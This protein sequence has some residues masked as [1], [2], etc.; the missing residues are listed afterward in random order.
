MFK[1]FYNTLRNFKLSSLLNIAGLTIAFV[2][3]II[4]M[5]QVNFDN[6][7]DTF[8]TKADRIYR[9]E[10]SDDSMLYSHNISR[11]IGE[12]L[13]NSSTDI[14]AYSTNFIDYISYKVVG[15][16]E[17][18]A[19]SMG[20]L[21]SF[22]PDMIDIFDFK[23]L[24]GDKECIADPNTIIISE[25]IAKKISPTQ[26]A[27]GKEILVSSRVLKIG[28]VY[29][30]F[31][32]NTFLQNHI[33]M[34][35]GNRYINDGSEWSF[36]YFV[37]LNEH[38]KKNDVEKIMN[39]W[40]QKNHADNNNK[41]VVRLHLVKDIYYSKDI[42]FDGN[43]RGDKM[44]SNILF[45]IAILIVVIA[46][47]NFLNFAMATTPLR[48]KSINLH[49]ILGSSVTNL[50]VWMVGEAVLIGVISYILAV[51]V[52][53]YLSNT[54]FTTYISADMKFDNQNLI[55]IIISGFVAII[56]GIL[57]GIL[58]A[59]Y[60]T[61]FPPMIVI[62]GSYGNSKKGNIFRTGLIAIQ[63]VV[64]ISL[65]I[66]AMLMITQNTFMKNH[67]IG[68]NRDNI[69]CANLPNAIVDKKEAFIDKL[70]SNPVVKDV[71]FSAGPIVS[72][73]KMGWGRDYKDASV[74]FDCF[75]VSWDYIRFMGMEIVSGRDFIK[76]DDLKLN[77]T[78][79]FNQ[80]AVDAYGFEV[81]DKIEGHREDD[82]ADIIGVVK[83]FNFQPMHYGI[84]PI[85]LYLFGAE[86]WY[87]LAYL[88]VRT[89]A[90]NTMEAK[91]YIEQCIKEFHIKS[92]DTNVMFMDESI[93]RLYKKE[94][95]LANLI[96]IFGTMA[97]I[98]SLT[99]IIGLIL[100]ETQYR[101]KEIG[102]RK[103]N[104]ATSSSV[105]IMFNKKFIILIGICFL[106]ATPISYFGINRW[107][108][109]F[110]YRTPIH[111]WVFVMAL[112]IVSFVTIVV[113]TLQ[114]WRAATENPINSMKNE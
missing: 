10:M 55:I 95:N 110:T 65:I 73:S 6:T 40:Y 45:S 82:H 109:S 114:A 104:G 25:S 2:G 50:R 68:F 23:F 97:M 99:G 84:N 67:P 8:H 28:G 11:P 78:I 16:T 5:I 14:E 48:L 56:T 76:E 113:I 86:P 33:Y 83:N 38:N 24:E 63:Y 9:I 60:S 66:C 94:D 35:V 46:A 59:I 52:V 4:I 75:P 70:M 34:N 58:P 100:Y 53:Y 51:G 32:K 20:V 12:A 61:S 19:T 93:G 36:P 87:K 106:I 42:V 88:N 92:S 105:L 43:P 62:N 69:L 107:L 49:K 108:D 27:L 74:S 64:S 29:K 112:L 90:S 102:L 15:D 22:S 111:W 44:T 77:G 89:T 17:T 101:R 31:P 37:L 13:S 57:A 96:L 21:S 91:Q 3:F 80:K 26:S 81:G 103:I 18:E 71:T 7:F 85:A 1:N 54:S 41:L 79:I 39:E 72:N 30:D 47:I 98:I